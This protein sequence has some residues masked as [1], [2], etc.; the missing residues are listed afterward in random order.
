[1]FKLRIFEAVNQSNTSVKSLE[2]FVWLHQCL[3]EG[4]SVIIRY[5][6]NKAVYSLE[7]SNPELKITNNAERALR[8]KLMLLV[9][10]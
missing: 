7:K 4:S 8:N 5:E 10:L 3:Y 6:Q 2:L 9:F 1:M